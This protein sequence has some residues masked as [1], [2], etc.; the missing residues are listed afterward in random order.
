[1]GLIFR[2]TNLIL[3]KVI[4]FVVLILGA[5]LLIHRLGYEFIPLNAI[6]SGIIGAT[7]F[8]LGFLLNGVMADYKES[9][10]IPGELA[11][12]LATLADEAES[13]WMSKGDP[14]AL[15]AFSAIADLSTS[16]RDWI[17]RKVRT[18]ELLGRITDL[19]EQFIGLEPLIPANYIV[20]MKQEQN[21]LR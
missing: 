2:R 8:L 9:E 21:N 18:R 17:H 15:A 13:A 10:K 7:V 5:K 16:T 3:L 14:A 19:N 12:C 1:M 11:A 20:R 6:F 4:P